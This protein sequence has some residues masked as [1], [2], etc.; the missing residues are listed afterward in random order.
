MALGWQLARSSSLVAHRSVPSAHG[1]CLAL[2]QTQAQAHAHSSPQTPDNAAY[3][4]H[5]RAA[6]RHRRGPP[7]QPKPERPN[8][9]AAARGPR[10][11]L[12]G[13]SALH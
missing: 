3:T 2:L 4:A 11:C 6:S 13:G 1:S 12:F 5:G 9:A 10:G 7:N 8:K